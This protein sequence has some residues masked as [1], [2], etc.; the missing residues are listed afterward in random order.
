MYIHMMKRVNL[1][2]PSHLMEVPRVRML[3]VN[4]LTFGSLKWDKIM[5][6]EQP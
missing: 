2:I 1:G 3:N 6:K 5:E 4:I